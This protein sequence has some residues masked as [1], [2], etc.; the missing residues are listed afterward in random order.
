[1]PDAYDGTSAS[2]AGGPLQRRTFLA[3]AGAGALAVAG[4]GTATQ[5]ATGR[6]PVRVS[7]VLLNGRVCTATH[8]RAPAQAVAVG[9]DGSGMV[10][11]GQRADLIVLDR[12]IS[13]V[14]VKDIRATKVRYTP[15]SGRVVHD[16]ASQTGHAGRCRGGAAHGCAGRRPDARRFLLP[17]A[18]TRADRPA[19]QQAERS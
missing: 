12:D 14:P 9:S 19:G 18:L 16:T 6:H 4:A 15:V 13:K 8:G 10:R 1:M 3:A 5:A 7:T 2:A 17:G 11:P